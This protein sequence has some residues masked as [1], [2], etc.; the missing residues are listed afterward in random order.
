MC[1]HIQI[2]DFADFDWWY[3]KN[4]PHSGVD[5][6]WLYSLIVR[7]ESEHQKPVEAAPNPPWHCAHMNVEMTACANTGNYDPHADSYWY[8]FRC[9]DCNQYWHE[10]QLKYL[11]RERKNKFKWEKERNIV[12]KSKSY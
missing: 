8:E 5:A 12:K 11:D 2:T 9:L 7:Y 10:D 1:G 3:N 4:Y 6:Q